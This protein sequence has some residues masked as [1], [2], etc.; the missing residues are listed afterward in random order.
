MSLQPHP[1][2]QRA[3]EAPRA[4]VALIRTR[5]AD[6]EYLF[7]RRAENPQDTWSGHFA[8]PGGRQDKT[9]QDLLA[10]AIRETREECGITLDRSQLVSE[11]PWAVAGKPTGNP[12]QVAPFVF[13]LESRP[14]ISLAALE[15]ADFHWLSLSHLLNPANHGLACLSHYAPEMRF[16]CVRVGASLEDGAIWGFTY[17]VL[18]NFIPGFPALP[19][20]F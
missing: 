20:P 9:D 5:G 12:M 17:G 10:T 11:L 8:F 2:S 16:P 18:R 7:L 4:A 13:E 1:H 14:E 19:M 6:P 15:I 3:G